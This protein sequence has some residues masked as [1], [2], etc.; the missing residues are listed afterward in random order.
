VHLR[1]DDALSLLETLAD[2][3]KGCVL[4]FLTLAPSASFGVLSGTMKKLPLIASDAI[5]FTRNRAQ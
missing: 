4:V 1:V 2:A 3:R 5:R